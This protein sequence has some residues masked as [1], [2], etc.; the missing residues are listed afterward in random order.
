MLLRKLTSL[1]TLDLHG[2]ELGVLGVQRLTEGVELP[3]LLT[4]RIKVPL[5]KNDSDE[6][7]VLN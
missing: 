2:T 5:K 7:K 1:E 4:L 3:N 6:A